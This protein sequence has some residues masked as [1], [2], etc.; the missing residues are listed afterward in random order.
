VRLP[1]TLWRYILISYLRALGLSTVLFTAVLYLFF[2]AKLS[3][4]IAR[5]G[6]SPDALIGA[7]PGLLPHVLAYSLPLACMAAA[8]VAFG[9]LAE[10]GEYTATAAAGI[11]P[12]KLVAPLLVLGALLSALTLWLHDD[13]T[14]HAFKYV[15]QKLLAA[16]SA[17]FEHQLRPGRS[18]LIP[19]PGPRSSYYVHLFE[20]TPGGK[21]PVYVVYFHAGVRDKAIRAEDCRVTF[22]REDDADVV[23]LDLIDAESASRDGGLLGAKHLQLS[24]SVNRKIADYLNLGRTNSTSPLSKNIEDRENLAKKVRQEPAGSPD[25]EFYLRCYRAVTTEVHRKRAMALACFALTLLGAALGL[26]SRRGSR[27][28]S[29]ALSIIVCCVVY[30]PAIVV[31]KALA[32]TGYVPP[33]TMWV[34]TALTVLA[35]VLLLGRVGRTAA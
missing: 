5:F 4:S 27:S 24:F 23:R 26:L 14:R 29:V 32:G 2:L 35:G 12:W 10:S 16:D 15:R 33:G 3:R 9:S 22:A 20:R 19:L 13:G 11:S 6:L 18:L 7:L 25:R 31:I 28:A 21:L 17:T 8:V 30:L 34:P 1:V